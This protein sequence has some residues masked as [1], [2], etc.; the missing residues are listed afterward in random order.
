MS[1]IIGADHGGCVVVELE[2]VQRVCSMTIEAGVSGQPERVR[3]TATDT[4]SPN[5]ADYGM[6]RQ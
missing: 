4:P 2:T 6:E 1:Q 3:T 5:A